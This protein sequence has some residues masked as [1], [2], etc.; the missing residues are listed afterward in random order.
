MSSGCRTAM[1][2]NRYVRR[3]E[4]R[5]VWASSDD[6]GKI[7]TFSERICVAATATKKN[8]NRVYSICHSRPKNGSPAAATSRFQWTPQKSWLPFNF[9]EFHNLFSLDIGSLERSFYSFQ[10]MAVPTPFHYHLIE[11]LVVN[12]SYWI[13]FNERKPLLEQNDGQRTCWRKMN[14]RKQ[15]NGMSPTKKNMTA[16]LT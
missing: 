10:V 2:S 13:T 12:T 9:I 6:S 16:M 4:P 7:C 5:D 11:A 15:S 8:D 14:R 3:L 1:K